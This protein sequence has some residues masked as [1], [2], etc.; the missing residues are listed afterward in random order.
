MRYLCVDYG[1]KRIGLAISS[2]D[3]AFPRGVIENDAGLFDTLAE[4]IVKEKVSA[5]VV[6]DTRSFGGLEN[7]ITKEAE[8][9]VDRL[10]VGTGLPVVLAVEAGSSVEA[11]RYAPS[12]QKHD[13]AAAAFILQRY[14][15]MSVSFPE[16]DLPLGAKLR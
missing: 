14:L 7:P 6:G 16:R 15:D 12:D 2:E 4:I 10:R 11:L 9:F 8:T 13:D 3:I 1:E 5:I